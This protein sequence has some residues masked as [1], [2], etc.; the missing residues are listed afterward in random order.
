M[1][2]VSMYRKFLSN[3]ALK[4]NSIVYSVNYRKA[5]E[6]PFPAAQLDA[7]NTAV[8]LYKNSKKYKID[9]DNVVFS[10]TCFFIY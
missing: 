8:Y 9:T 2:S 4:T 5:P 7:F 6:H 1:C 3:L 10:G